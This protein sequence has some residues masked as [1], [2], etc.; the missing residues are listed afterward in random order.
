MA[1]FCAEGRPTRFDGRRMHWVEPY[2]GDSFSVVM[3]FV[4]GPGTLS[5]SR[6]MLAEGRGGVFSILLLFVNFGKFLLHT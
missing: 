4:Q 3:Y 5:Q 6:Q 1:A 2:F